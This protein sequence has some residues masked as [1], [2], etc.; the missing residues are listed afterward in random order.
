MAADNSGSGTSL[1]D[2]TTMPEHK[3]IPSTSLEDRITMPEH[4]DIPSVAAKENSADSA[5]AN[6][7][8]ATAPS[9]VPGQTTSWADDANSPVAA[10]DTA[11]EE[12]EAKGNELA[13]AQVDGATEFQNGSS[14]IYEPTYD[15]DVKLSDVQ[16]DP[17]NPLYSIKS[18]DE[19][20]L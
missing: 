2:R 10:N 19:L 8:N 7:M 20:G 9:F 3:D 13:K 5:S 17:N 12:A 11:A 6:G 4:K 14:S 18:F 16:A 15:V 1:E